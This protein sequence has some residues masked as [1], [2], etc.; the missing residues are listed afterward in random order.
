MTQDPVFGE[1]FTVHHLDLGADDEGPVVATLVHREAD[2]GSDVGAGNAAG[3][4]SAAGAVRASDARASS[5]RAPVLIMHGWSDYVLDR[6]LLDHLGRRGHDV[7]ALDLRKHGRSLMPWQTPTAIDH[8]SRYDREI[9]MALRIIGWHRPPIIIGHST[10][11][12][13][14]ALYAQRRPGAVRGL[15]LNSPWLEM[16]LGPSTRRLLTRPVTAIARRAGDRSFLPPAATHAARATHREF[17]GLYDYDL[18]LKPARG[19]PLPASTMAAVLDGQRR[20][21]AAGPLLLPILV[22]HSARTRIGVR[23]HESMRRSDTVLDVHAI[24]MAARHLGRR[25]QVTAL[26]GARHEVFLSDADVRATAFE[27]LDGWLDEHG[28][29]TSEN[30]V[31]DALG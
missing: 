12:L 25:V 22:L 18:G 4:G 11:G 27:V 8:L 6:G 3:T 2:A 5:D 14:A 7:F 13:V 29:G 31:S 28:G 30:G 9:D 19:H 24:A 21:A 16:H 15:V 17:G 23:W 20:L 26:D 10:G 1:G